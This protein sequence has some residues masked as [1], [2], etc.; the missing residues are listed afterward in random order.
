VYAVIP[1]LFGKNDVL[2][3]K[4]PRPAPGYQIELLDGEIILFHPASMKVMHSNRT[5]ALIW[6]LCDGQRTVTEIIQLLSAVYPES[7]KEIQADVRET[8][9]TFAKQGAITWL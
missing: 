3:T 7:A 4:R 5:G 8:L 2:D 6:Q 1:L 9:L